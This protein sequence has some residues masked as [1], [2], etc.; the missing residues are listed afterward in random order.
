M[1][2]KPSLASAVALDHIAGADWKPAREATDRRT[3]QKTSCA[4]LATA[5]LMADQRD[6][7]ETGRRRAD[8][9]V[10]RCGKRVAERRAEPQR[11][12]LRAH[13]GWIESGCAPASLILRMSL[14][15]NRFPLFR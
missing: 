12:T 9:P 8:I 6:S 13:P 7:S 4:T 5:A 14:S 15:E 3:H 11:P 2:A 10:N 1:D